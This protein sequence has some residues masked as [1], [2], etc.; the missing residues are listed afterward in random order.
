VV[1][2][3]GPRFVE[4]YVDLLVE[5]AS[6]ELVVVDYKTDHVPTPA[7]RAT[8]TTCYRPQLAAYAE[9]IASATGRPVTRGCLIFAGVDHA[10]Q[11][12]IDFRPNA[13]VE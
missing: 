1:A 2:P 4:G 12:Q 9:M 13:Q 6:G 7:H 8:K 5:T 11:V 10:D 3:H